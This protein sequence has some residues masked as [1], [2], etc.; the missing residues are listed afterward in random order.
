M[1]DFVE[2]SLPEVL[3]IEIEEHLRECAK[4]NRLVRQFSPIWK[5]FASRERK[6]PSTSLWPALIEK[7]QAE[8]KPQLLRNKILA[9]VKNSLRPAVA[10][11]ILLAGMFFGYHLGNVPDDAG[12]LVS[13]QGYFS[14]YLET[15][16]DFPPGSVGD[17][18]LKYT[19]QERKDMP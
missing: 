6:A 12:E 13:G 17:F 19:I 2:K 15:F 10:T 1:I 5:D 8:K 4:C 3:Q 14:E 16:E 7:I 11:L 9:G 18:Y